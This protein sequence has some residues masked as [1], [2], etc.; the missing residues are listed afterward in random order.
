MHRTMLMCAAI[1][2]RMLLPRTG[3]AFTGEATTYNQA[4]AAPVDA[5]S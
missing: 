1:A 5:D 4:P 3:D 2:A